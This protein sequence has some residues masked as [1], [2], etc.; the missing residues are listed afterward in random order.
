MRHTSLLINQPPERLCRFSVF[1]NLFLLAQ[2]NKVINAPTKED[3]REG[4]EILTNELGVVFKPPKVKTADVDG[5]AFDPSVVSVSGSVSGGV[6]NHRAAHFEWLCDVGAKLGL[7]FADLGKRRHGSAA[8]LHFCDQLYEIYGNENP[9]IS[10]GASFA[11]EHWANAGF[12]DDLVDGFTLLNGKGEIK[13]PLGFWKFHQALEAQHAAHTMDE[14][15]EALS[16]DGFVVDE[17][18]FEKAANEMLDA[19][20]V[21]WD[22]LEDERKA[23]EHRGLK[24]R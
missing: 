22:G 23:I 19:C 8:T 9:S 3:M 7:E 2:L 5:A 21:F 18:A 17:A 12:W 6:Y 20:A 15:E 4:K 1:S 24:C 14:L 13:T 11:I 16:A 10:L